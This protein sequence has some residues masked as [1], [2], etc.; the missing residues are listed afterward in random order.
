M[1]SSISIDQA[2]R[3]SRIEIPEHELADLRSR[4]ERT[5]WSDELIGAGADYGVPIAYVRRLVEYWLGRYD[6][7]KWETRL[8]RC[9]PSETTIVEQRGTGTSRGSDD[10]AE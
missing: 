8:N 1:A 10:L 3:P 9:A 7:R 5:R 6:W 2:V 4:L